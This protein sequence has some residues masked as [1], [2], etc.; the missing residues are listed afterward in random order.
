MKLGCYLENFLNFEGS[1]IVFLCPGLTSAPSQLLVRALEFL[2]LLA[3]DRHTDT[4][5]SK[6]K[7]VRKVRSS[8]K[9]LECNK[10]A[11]LD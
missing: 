9:W 4:N 3:M 5:T 8:Q 7:T 10:N 11:E 6:L 1:T 2:L